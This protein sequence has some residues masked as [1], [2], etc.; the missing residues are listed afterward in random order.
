MRGERQCSLPA[1]RIPRRD[2][3]RPSQAVNEPYRHE[4]NNC[5]SEVKMQIDCRVECRVE[6][7]VRQ[8]QRCDELARHQRQD[9]PVEHLS[10]GVVA[11]GSNIS[12]LG[13]HVWALSRKLR[14]T[15]L[16]SWPV[17]LVSRANVRTGTF[18]VQ[19]HVISYPCINDRMARWLLRHVV[20][21]RQRQT[22]T[23]SSQP[24]GDRLRSLLRHQPQRDDQRSGR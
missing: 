14:I 12:F 15:N 4:G 16:L 5:K 18:I 20:V 6:L 22:R 23:A 2:G 9:R 10:S 17:A 24:C 21:R 11:T 3:Y 13:D 8:Q 7:N 1:R 19:I